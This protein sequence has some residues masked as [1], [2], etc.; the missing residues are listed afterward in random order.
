MKH[1]S[2]LSFFILSLFLF[3]SCGKQN[4]PQHEEK[5]GLTDY[6]ILYAK[7]FRVKKM[8]AYTEAI[9]ANPWDTTKI[10]RKY[11]LVEKGKELPNPMPDGQLVRVPVSRVVSYYTI[12][13]AVFRE[14]DALSVVKGVCESEYIN[15]DDIQRGVRN[16]SILDLGLASNP[17]VEKVIALEP[18]A[19]FSSPIRGQS[20][21][22]VQ[23]TGIPIIETPDYMEATPLAAAEWIRFYS[24]FLGKE[25][26]ADSLFHLVETN[27]KAV[28]LSMAE[29]KERPT[30]FLDLKYGNTWYVSGGNS[31]MARMLNDAG[32]HYIWSDDHSTGAMPLS[33]ETVLNKA[34]NADF[35]LIKYNMP[36]TLTYE[37]LAKEMEGYRQFGAF[38]NRNIFECNTR[39][40]KYYED[41]PIHPDYILKDLAAVL[42]PDLFP[43]YVP[44]YYSRMK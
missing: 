33:F 16:G 29:A 19:I 34:A 21:G 30:V 42:H 5:N 7:G 2:L 37:R 22:S 11:I 36:Q 10:L 8:G 27:Y 41:L 35:W 9:V 14:L 24:L 38:R 28:Q 13:C 31:F 15:I 18:E 23:K 20:Y 32:A 4:K 1:L 12:H 17:N 44:R 43:G 26:M 40:K 39:Y 3:A 6:P 25:A